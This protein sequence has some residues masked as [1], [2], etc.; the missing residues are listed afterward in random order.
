MSDNQENVAAEDPSNL[1]L[2]SEQEVATP[3][4]PSLEEELKK[5]KEDYL[6]LA[7]EFENFKK[8]QLKERAESFQYANERL[9]RDLL[10]AM[11]GIQMAIQSMSDSPE[12]KA[13]LDGV[14]MIESMLFSALAKHGV[15]KIKVDGLFD[16]NF[17]EAV[18]KVKLEGKQKNE[19]TEVQQEGY[20]LNGRLLRPARVVV[21]E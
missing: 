3:K 6:Y 9:I 12:H 18:K 15:E 20:L 16:M 5:A 8:R 10:G 19:I 7:A 4:T 17:H 21:A 13:F 2:P 14:K 11:D 1:E